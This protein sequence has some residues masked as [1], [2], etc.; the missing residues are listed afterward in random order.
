LLLWAQFQICSTRSVDYFGALQSID[1]HARYKLKNDFI[2]L[3]IQIE[4]KNNLYFNKLSLLVSQTA[5][6]ALASTVYIIKVLGS[7]ELYF[8]WI[9]M[10]L[11]CSSGI[12]TGAPTLAAKAFG[13]KNFVP[14]YG[15]M[16]LFSVSDI[17]L[18]CVIILLLIFCGFL[19]I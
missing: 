7:K 17:V 12:F 10:I 19:N 15:I 4:K 2:K 6:L 5:I 11:F 14:I 3:Q 16:L 9:C 18:I 13:Q 8:V 1:F